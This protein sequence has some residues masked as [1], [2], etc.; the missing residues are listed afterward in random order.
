MKDGFGEITEEITDERKDYIS[1]KMEIIFYDVIV[2]AVTSVFLLVLYEGPVKLTQRGELQQMLLAFVCV[3]ACR[4]VGKIY[5]QIWRYG[6]IQCYM[7]L[8]CTDCV[9]FL[10]Y[11]ILESVLPVA[12]ISF[13]RLLVLSTVNT[14]G[15]LIMRMSYRYA[16]KCSNLE[17]FSGKILAALLK[18]FAGIEVGETRD[19]QKI[20]VAIIGA[21]N[22]GVTL[23][24]ELLAN[25][26]A[27]Y[28]PKCFVDIDK[29]KDGREI[30]GLP[31]LSENETTFQKLKK[32][33]IQEIIFAL[34]SMADE[35][36]TER[37]LYYKNA[38]YKVKMYDYPKMQM[39]GGKRAL[40]EFDIEELLFRAPRKLTNEK[41]KDYYNNKVILIT[42]G[43]GSIGSELCRQIVKM[44]PEKLIILD[45]YENGAYDLL[46]ELRIA[47]GNE[48]GLSVEI[49][50]ITDSR[51]MERVFQN[52]IRR[53]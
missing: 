52:I 46:Q 32:Y 30:Q 39:A 9:A 15:A 44:G 53:S 23:A 4:L 33:G 7:R 29:S 14:M 5:G 40:R 12:H 6:G 25:K 37:Y 8:V 31:V 34:P 38:G 43:G 42:G 11:V 13:P 28:V 21:G 47:Y 19:D 45:I 49:A 2:F 41:T 24:G 48:P 10:I 16:Y 51:A 22:V 26:M 3:F 27:S 1:Y 35:R 17:T 18:I 36:R 50:S 20:K